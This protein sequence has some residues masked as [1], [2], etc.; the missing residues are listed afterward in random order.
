MRCARTETPQRPLSE[1]SARDAYLGVATLA[2]AER[3]VGRVYSCESKTECSGVKRLILRAVSVLGFLIAAWCLIAGML[4]P[5]VGVLVLGLEVLAITLVATNVGGIRR[6]IPVLRDPERAVFGWVAVGVVAFGV[7][8]LADA[9]VRDSF[10]DGI[11]AG[12]SARSEG[13]NE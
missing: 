2:Q 13:G 6:H 4:A 12:M 9:T 11:R 1:Q 3:R 7:L 10:V 8:L 5:D